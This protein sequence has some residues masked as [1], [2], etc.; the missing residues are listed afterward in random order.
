M[1]VDVLRDVKVCEHGAALAVAACGSA[2]GALGATVTAWRP[3]PALVEAELLGWDTNKQVRCDVADSQTLA[4]ADV[5]LL[6]HPTDFAADRVVAPSAVVVRVG[7]SSSGRYPELLAQSRSGWLG[8]VG[9][10]SDGPIRIGIPAVTAST[11]VAAV[12]AVFAGLISRLRDGMGQT[13]VVDPLDVAFSLAHNLITSESDF[14]ERAGFAGIPWSP[15]ERGSQCSDGEIVFVFHRD[16]DSF[17]EFCDWLGA[18]AVGADPRFSTSRDR[19]RYRHEL[20]VELAP[21]LAG[22]TTAAAVDKLVEL[23][24]LV[25]RYVPPQDLPAHPQVRE[26]GLIVEDPTGDLGWLAAQPFTVDGMRPAPN[27]TTRAWDGP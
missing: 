6:D 8:C 2:L 17:Q 27:H 10:Q 15:P 23:G 13:I 1:P 19:L 7:T 21:G 26:L 25:G 24:M 12:Q 20:S 11:A 3:N 5:L 16:D 4:E 14:D 18:P 22:K 9:S